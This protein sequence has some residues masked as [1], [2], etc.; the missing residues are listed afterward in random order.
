MTAIIAK[1][2]R[3]RAFIV[4]ERVFEAF[5]MI[6][7]MAWA[8]TMLLDPRIFKLFP[9]FTAPA[10]AYGSLFAALF[11]FS[12]IGLGTSRLSRSIAAL[13]MSASAIVWLLMSVEFWLSYP[14]ASPWMFY[15]PFLAAMTYIFAQDIEKEC[16][17]W[18]QNV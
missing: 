11:I 7:V 16:K 8:I 4:K 5:N 17:T 14:P 2:S 6:H 3:A 10:W 13:N 1:V 18:G 9:G 15:Y 12:V